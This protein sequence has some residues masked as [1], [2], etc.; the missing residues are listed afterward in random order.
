MHR[1]GQYRATGMAVRFN[2]RRSSCAQQYKNGFRED[3]LWP[4]LVKVLLAEHEQIACL[5]LGQ[6]VAADRQAPSPDA[7]AMARLKEQRAQLMDL[8][9]QG[10]P[11]ADALRAVER[12]VA[13]VKAA[14]VAGQS[15]SA[16]AIAQLGQEILGG[17]AGADA[18]MDAVLVQALQEPYP[19][20]LQDEW[21]AAL[22]RACTKQVVVDHKQIVRIDLNL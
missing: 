13:A 11:V 10:L 20:V 6:A 14:A 4:Q 15:K 21:T 19:A 18:L 8:Q 9:Q 16:M 1:G 12:E 22:V 5:L 17:E 3:Q 2:C 7:E